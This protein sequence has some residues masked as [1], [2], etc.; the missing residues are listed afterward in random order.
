MSSSRIQA[1]L[2]ESFRTEMKNKLTSIFDNIINPV[3]KAN[4]TKELAQALRKVF[5]TINKGGT[6]GIYE[7]EFVGVLL[8]KVI[9]VLEESL[10]SNEKMEKRGLISLRIPFGGQPLCGLQVMG[11]LETRLPSF[12][13]VFLLDVNEE[14][15]PNIE[16]INPPMP[17]QIKRALGLPDRE[18]EELIMKYHFERLVANIANIQ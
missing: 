17:Y 12:D 1:T 11:A 18:R 15:V 6:I 3:E 16:E 4:T 5:D 2:S 7:K 10:F 8:E 14:I 9:P 13:E